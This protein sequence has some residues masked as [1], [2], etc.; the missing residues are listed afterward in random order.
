M[1]AL[2]NIKIDCDS[3]WQEEEV[4]FLSRKER[5][6]ISVVAFQSNLMH[7]FHNLQELSL[8]DYNDVEVVFEIVQVAEK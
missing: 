6:D 1:R 2:T 7:S 3:R 5:D 4:E 8:Y